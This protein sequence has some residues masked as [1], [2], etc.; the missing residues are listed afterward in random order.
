M[1]DIIHGN[2]GKKIIQ[3]VSIGVKCLR[4]LCEK[5]IENWVS[6]LQHRGHL[7]LCRHFRGIGIK[8]N[9]SDLKTEW[10]IRKWKQPIRKTSGKFLQLREVEKWS[11]SW[12]EKTQLLRSSYQE[13]FHIG[14]GNPG[15][16][17]N[18]KIHCKCRVGKRKVVAT[19]WRRWSWEASEQI[20]QEWWDKDVNRGGGHQDGNEQ[21]ERRA[22]IEEEWSLLKDSQQSAQIIYLE[23]KL[24]NWKER[25]CN[26]ILQ[27]RKL[28]P[29]K[30]SS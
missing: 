8:L 26:L 7:G 28:K 16:C 2:Q 22:I 20:V 23:T 18:Q 1:E 10:E 17:Q 29:K 4:L 11:G 9:W 12:R 24:W 30:W 13:P 27:K 3:G 15:R 25:R 6:S 19:T 14:S 21:A 5:K